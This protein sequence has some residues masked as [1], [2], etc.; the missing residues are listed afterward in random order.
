MRRGL[1]SRLAGGVLSAMVL[2]A[3]T[4]LSVS[5]RPAWADTPPWAGQ[6]LGESHPAAAGMPRL[7]YASPAAGAA[8]VAHGA[9]F[10]LNRGTC[11][12]SRVG[13]EAALIGIGLL[14]A[15]LDER[16]QDCAGAALAY[17]PDAQL[18]AWSG[19]NGSL[20]RIMA[21]RSWMS[22]GHACREVEATTLADGRFRQV[23][24]VACRRADGRWAL[25]G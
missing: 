6:W 3:A 18:V 15:G 24:G 21:L 9:P 17:L 10:G 14:A 5:G 4:A 16:D 1:V 2:S 7:D 22:G 23:R 8:P 12:R 25:G 20:H 13:A 19:E 11:D